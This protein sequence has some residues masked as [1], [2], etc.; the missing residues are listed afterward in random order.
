MKKVI[1]YADFFWVKITFWFTL[2]FLY[3]P[4]FILILYSFN[5]SKRNI[6]WRG[7]TF[8]YYEKLFNNQ[9]MIDAFANSMVIALANMVISVILAIFCAYSLWKL[10]QKKI[11]ISALYEGFLSIPIVIPEIC[12]GVGMLVFYQS[13]NWYAI[14]QGL[15]WPFNLNSIIIAH[16][17]FSFPFATMIIRARLNT[18]NREIDQGAID[19]GATPFR[20][21]TDFII[22]HLKPAIITASFLSI[23]LSLDDFVITFFTSTPEVVTLPLK[24]YSMV[25]FSITPEVNAASTIFILLTLIIVF[26]GLIS[27]RFYLFTKNG[28]KK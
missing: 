6:V 28:R 9:S 25:R 7:F 5:D 1:N 2:A 16:V 13:F 22:P 19:L 17:T 4:I 20:V 18:F 15:S 24:I 26:L 23:A 10:S 27:Y 3:F 14:G 12:M 8:K 11:V 21:F